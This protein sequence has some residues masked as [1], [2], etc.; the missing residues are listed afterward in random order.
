M[1]WLSLLTLVAAFG[2]ATGAPA[3]DPIRPLPT[4]GRTAPQLGGLDEAMQFFMG[5]CGFRAGTM[6]VMR[7]GHLVFERG[8]GFADSEETRAL[9]P[10][11]RMRIASV[12]KV[13][14]AAAVKRLVR[15]GKISLETPVFAFIG[16]DL[17]RTPHAD[18]RL[19]QV[20]VGH[21]LRHRGG[22]DREKGFD[23][24][25]AE[26]KIRKM[27]GISRR[28]NTDDIIRFMLMEPLQFSP[29]SRQA[30]SN[31]GYALLGKV[32][33]QAARQPYA[34]YLQRSFFRPLGLPS[35]EPAQA[36]PLANEIWY[37]DP[38]AERLPIEA[39]QAAGGWV[40]SAADLCRFLQS[41]WIS[42]DP[43]RQRE[44]PSY[45]F[46]G[47]LPGTTAMALQRPDGTDIAV[48]FN[49]RNRNYNEQNEALRK[50]MNHA[51]DR[52]ANWPGE[53]A[54]N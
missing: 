50:L 42:G 35:V 12:S 16:I 34:E 26:Q 30:Y 15:E 31:F 44:G 28:P 11:T 22:W 23:P 37:D 40:A 3:S 45:V 13:F 38:A 51:L 19:A 41:Y 5:E 17:A 25:L 4:T 24:M 14:T 32:V 10:G 9:Q 48:L 53:P 52:V 20:T 54:G 8:Y 21:L 27:L 7:R 46:F 36:K 2:L 39:L 18:P 1:R 43:R 29:G 49:R 6:A 47:S 33:E